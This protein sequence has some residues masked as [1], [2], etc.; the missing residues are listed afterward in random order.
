MHDHVEGGH[1]LLQQTHKIIS[2][3]Q[4]MQPNISI[5]T[6]NYNSSSYIS[7]TIES[8]LQQT[9]PHWEMII[10]DDCS[11]DD[12]INI[13]EK[14]MYQDPRI[15]LIKLEKNSGPVTA[16][17]RGITQAQGRYLTFIDSDDLWL[18]NFLETSITMLQDQ[19]IEFTFSSYKRHDEQMRP[20]L[21]DFIVPHKA[22]YYDILKTCSISNLTAMY[23][24]SR[25]GKQYLE[26]AVRED[27][28]YWLKILKKVPYAYGTQEPLAIYRIRNNSRSRNKVKAALGQWDAYRKSEKLN[29]FKSLYY[30]SH[31]IYNGIRKYKS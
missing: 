4:M 25:I 1:C 11:T 13:I 22:S 6:P 17:N 20:L 14:Y 29:L 28:V 21:N 10:I 26:D 8:V 9:Y 15:K 5:I 30:F 31:Y 23:D 24:T 27:Y 3:N 18:E 16:R 2:G 7:Q 19:K 12:S